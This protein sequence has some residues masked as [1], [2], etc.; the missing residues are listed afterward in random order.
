MLKLQSSLSTT[1][2]TLFDEHSRIQKHESA[3]TILRSFYTLRLSCAET[4]RPSALIS[5]SLHSLAHPPYP[6]PPPRRR[7]YYE[8]RKLHLSEVL[9]AD[10]SK[11]DNRMR[12]VAA[13]VA[14][15]LKIANVKKAVLVATLQKEGYTPFE[16]AAKK[17]AAEAEDGADEADEAEEE[18]DPKAASARGYDYLL[19]MPLWSL[20]AEKVEALRAELNAKEAELKKLLATTTK[21]LWSAD[22]D[23]FLLGLDEVEAQMAADEAGVPLKKGGAKAKAKPKP[24]KSKYAED[25]EDDFMDD[26]DDFDEDSDDDYGA[27]KKPTKKAPKKKEAKLAPAPTASSGTLIAPPPIVFKKE[28][29]RKDAWADESEV[30]SRPGSRMDDVA[31]ATA[32]L[33]P[34]PLGSVVVSLLLVIVHCVQ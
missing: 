3:E 33:R 23:A 24:K 15:S 32:C 29:G 20:T 34:L 12:F 18:A 31:A 4:R 10:W 30:D 26:D 6:P 25:S 9:T 17:K 7:R 16:P 13:V 27:K 2:M 14:G 28:R 1:N 5:R 21:Q 8:K 19:G 22:L 11:L